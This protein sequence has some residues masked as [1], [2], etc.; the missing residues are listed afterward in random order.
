VTHEDYDKWERFPKRFMRW[1]GACLREERA[2]VKQLR[3]RLAWAC[4]LLDQSAREQGRLSANVARDA[5]LLRRVAQLQ[6]AE[7]S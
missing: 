3:R 6:K 2:E 5:A 7:D 4:D 1:L